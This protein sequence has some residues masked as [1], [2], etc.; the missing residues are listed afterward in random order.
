M[1]LIWSRWRWILN[2]KNLAVITVRRQ[3]RII[4]TVFVTDKGLDQHRFRHLKHISKKQ[5]LSGKPVK[6]EQ[7]NRQLWEHVRRMNTDAA[8]KTAACHCAGVREVPGLCVAL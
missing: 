1:I 2:V 4:E 6:A 7:S 8:R 5:W 3:Q